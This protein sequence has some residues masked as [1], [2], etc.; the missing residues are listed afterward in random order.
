MKG[1]Q[2]ISPF[3]VFEERV[4]GYTVSMKIEPDGEVF[5][6][7]DGSVLPPMGFQ[8]MNPRL[9][10][11]LA[12]AGRRLWKRALRALPP[13]VYYCF[14]LGERRREVYISAGW[15]PAPLAGSLALVYYHKV[16]PLPPWRG[17]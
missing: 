14:P 15:K 2:K 8:K 4:G 6:F 1:R 12:L 11:R 7:V 3:F 9:R 10:I 17:E 5:L 16:P 13:G